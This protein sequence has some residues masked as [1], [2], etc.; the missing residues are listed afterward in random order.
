MLK[1]GRLILGTMGVFVLSMGATAELVL[2]DNFEGYTDGTIMNGLTSPGALGGLWDADDT[3]AY[4]TLQGLI[5]NIPHTHSSSNTGSQASSPT[6]ILSSFQQRI[7][8]LQSGVGLHIKH[9]HIAQLCDGLFGW[10]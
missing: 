8:C 3:S 1:K 2:V 6:G 7:S 4:H 5:E 9:T 10:A